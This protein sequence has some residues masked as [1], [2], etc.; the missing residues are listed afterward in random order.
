MVLNYPHFKK[1]FLK[2]TG[3]DL[4]SYK[5][6]QMERRIQQFMSRLNIKDYHSYL[7]LLK[8][9]EGEKTRFL[10][11]LTINTTSFFRDPSVY[12]Y[13]RDKIIPEL[14][15]RKKG[16]VKAWSAGCS[17]GAEP[18]SLAI[19]FGE[20]TTPLRFKIV[21]TDIDNETLEKAREGLY[22]ANQLEHLSSKSLKKYFSRKGVFFRLKPFVKERVVFKKQDLLK[23]NI[24]KN[25]DLILCRN[26]LIYLKQEVQ[27][28]VLEG[29][30]YSLNPS[31]Y[32]VLGC[33]ENIPHPRSIG[34]KRV[35]IA[36][37]QKER[38]AN[39]TD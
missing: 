33:S 23:D 22:T 20:I 3:I 5:D 7:K 12:R 26:V 39:K 31:G 24:E 19:L 1:R 30:V 17:I 34:L 29:L 38:I 21:A 32:L 13:I 18:Y 28:K 6:Q 10:N 2:L 15:A 8:R 37:F 25:C 4:D 11:Y 35:S 36:I 16:K 14:L 9:D 27:E